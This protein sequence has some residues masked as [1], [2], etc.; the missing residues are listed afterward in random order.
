MPGVVSLIVRNGTRKERKM[1]ERKGESGVA[2]KKMAWWKKLLI[3]LLVILLLFCGMVGF[4]VFMIKKFTGDSLSVRGMMA[5]VGYGGFDLPDWYCRLVLGDSHEYPGLPELLANED[6]KAVDTKADYDK[7][8]LELLELYEENMYGKTPT[9]GFQTSFE[10]VE[11]GDALDGKALRQQV[12]IT[13]TTGKGSCDAMLLVYLPKSDKPCGVF[14]GENFSGNTMIWPDEEILPST[15]QENEE[16]AAADSADLWP[17]EDI[18]GRGYGVATMCY[19]DWGADDK[20]TYRERLLRLFDDEDTTAF[21]AWAF[22]FSRA[23]DYLSTLEEVD[24]EV[25]ASV[26]HSRLARVSLWAGACDTRIFLV[27]ASCGGGSMRSDVSGRIMDDGNSSH[28]FSETYFTYED[29]DGEFPVDMNVLYALAAPRHLY[30]SM[31]SGDLAAD[32]FSMV[33][34]LQDAKKVWKDVYGVD[35]ID[36]FSYYDLTRG[37]AVMSEG[38]GLHVHQGG[39]KMDAGD[40]GYYLD[41]MD[42]CVKWA[43]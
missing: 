6:G 42:E 12:K 8:R 16:H 37:E 11:S 34:M 22:G 19:L 27:T 32:P 28:W 43:K 7:R 13:V 36:D 39:H 1:R 14:V 2:K 4:S 15:T 31:G 24:A 35:V 25:I 21:S 9:E 33:D 29:R 23:V 3:V 38:I 10:V 30:V 41:Y 18:V 17:V 20:D 26:G 40:W 5:M